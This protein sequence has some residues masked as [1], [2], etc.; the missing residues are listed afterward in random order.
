MPEFNSENNDPLYRTKPQEEKVDGIFTDP[1][2][3]KEMEE[4]DDLEKFAKEVEND[5]KDLKRTPPLS[6]EQ[7]IL[8]RA[9]RHDL[10]ARVK[11]V[12]EI[13]ADISKNPKDAKRR[14]ENQEKL[15]EIVREVFVAACASKIS[16]KS[17]EE[18]TQK[19][20]LQNLNYFTRGGLSPLW[21]AV[22]GNRSP[23][24]M[25]NYFLKRCDINFVDAKGNHVGHFA[26]MIGAD[27]EMVKFLLRDE[28]GLNKNAKNKNG[29]TMRDMVLAKG[30]K[31][32][33]GELGKLFGMEFAAM[34]SEGLAAEARGR[35]RERVK[36]DEEVAKEKLSTSDKSQQEAL[37]KE[38]A[39]EKAVQE[40]NGVRRAADALEMHE[41]QYAE[42]QKQ[43]TIKIKLEAEKLLA[44]KRDLELKQQ[45]ELANKTAENDAAEAPEEGVELAEE[46]KINPELGLENNL[47]KALELKDLSKF[48]LGNLL[49]RAV[50]EGRSIL[51]AG[52][53]GM[54]ASLDHM[55]NGKSILQSMVDSGNHSMFN[56]AAF[57]ASFANLQQA[58]S[59]STDAGVKFGEHALQSAFKDVKEVGLGALKSIMSDELKSIKGDRDVVSKDR[60]GNSPNVTSVVN[61]TPEKSA[62][63]NTGGGAGI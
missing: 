3:D 11:E 15:K 41:K 46:P 54:G 55:E 8:L 37:L 17:L 19:H 43:M 57:S 32:F 47:E 16:A 45:E 59:K 25:E 9:I 27:K 26:V 10:K 30:D 33:A 42:A 49:F 40:A 48:D 36:G 34:T 22:A 60:P 50:M 39:A 63:E 23:K 13:K 51:A 56:M 61:V 29:M 28:F 14:E 24:E 5:L 20:N 44:E 2:F 53:M 58:I 38:A 7:K 18:F 62:Q 21:S 4:V 12:K 6:K 35:G 31:D 52:L 1:V